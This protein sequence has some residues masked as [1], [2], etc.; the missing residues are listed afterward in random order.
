MNINIKAKEATR[1]AKK[2]VWASKGGEA[3]GSPLNTSKGG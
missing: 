1:S 2:K 3:G